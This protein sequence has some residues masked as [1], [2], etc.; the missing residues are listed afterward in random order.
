MRVAALAAALLLAFSA[1]ACAEPSKS[2]TIPIVKQQYPGYPPVRLANVRV[3]SLGD[4]KVDFPL[5][6]DTGSAG[7]T[8]DCNL[9]LPWELCAPDGIKIEQELISDSIRV[10]T[11]RIVAQYGTYD[12]YGN[13]AY[14]RM[15]LGDAAHNV[16]TSEMPVLIRYKKVR[17]QT[18]EVVGGPL[19]PRGI[20]GVSPLGAQAGGLLHSPMDY[21]DPPEGL[22]RGFY[23][24]PL[25]EVWVTC[26]HEFDECPSVDALHIGIDAETKAQ[27]EMVPLG[28]SRSEHYIGFVDACLYWY[29]RQSCVPTLYDTGNS[30]IA[31]AGPPPEGADMALPISTKV[32]LVGPNKTKWEFPTLYVPEVEFAP[33]SDINLIG[34]RYF[35]TNGLLFDLE[36]GQIGFR[37]E[38]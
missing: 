5:L 17:R 6:F 14:A 22:A 24:T 13:L 20:V 23:L 11:R 12:E 4:R 33:N 16:T 21:I 9:V 36:L 38:R 30:T 25:G 7:V 18:G 15:S 27:F 29:G 28:A 10:T 1:L 34:I 19:W 31:I 8:I 32:T 35:E 37:I 3:L 2:L 26:M